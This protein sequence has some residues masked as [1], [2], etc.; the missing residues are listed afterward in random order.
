MI[1]SSEDI[2]GNKDETI[3]TSK[4]SSKKS[5]TSVSVSATPI[6][7]RQ[8]HQP[9]PISRLGKRYHFN[10]HFIFNVNT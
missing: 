5:R 3:N 1:K 8:I 9:R 10:L 4:A 2:Y 7:V 6:K